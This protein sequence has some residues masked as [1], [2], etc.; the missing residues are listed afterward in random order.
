MSVLLDQSTRDA[1]AAKN[2]TVFRDFNERVK[3][4]NDDYPYI[5]PMSDWV[6]ECAN[7]SCVKV[8]HMS[9]AEYEAVREGGSCFVVAPGEEHVWADV[10][11]VTKR[12]D[13]YW[14]V[15]KDGLA[16]ELAEE[17]DPRNDEGPLRLQT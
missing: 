15:E 8:I 12:N 2:Q 6:C 1:R 16:G 4:Q 11:H 14:V 10:E 17:S 7:E 3:V 5:V 13:R 9:P